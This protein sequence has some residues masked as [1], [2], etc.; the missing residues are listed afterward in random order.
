MMNRF[1]TVG[2]T[3]GLT[4]Y[5]SDL[6]KIIYS[7][8]MFVGRIGIFTVLVAITGNSVTSQMGDIDDGLKIQVG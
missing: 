6:E 2:F 7:I 8:V 1:S 4:P 5:I 3:L